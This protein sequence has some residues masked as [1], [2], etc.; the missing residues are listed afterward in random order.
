MV[1]MRHG[2]IFAGGSKLKKQLPAAWPEPAR[3]AVSM[4]SLAT[5]GKIIYSWSFTCTPVYSIGESPAI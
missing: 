5:G 3:D 4:A 1:G 2:L